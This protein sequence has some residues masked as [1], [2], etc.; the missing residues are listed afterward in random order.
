MGRRRP[1]RIRHPR[2]R[3]TC[4]DPAAALSSDSGSAIAPPPSGRPCANRVARATPGTGKSATTRRASST[5]S[6]R[7]TG[8]ACRT[9][10]TIIPYCLA[11]SGQS[12]V[13]GASTEKRS[14]TAFS[15]TPRPEKPWIGRPPPCHGF[16]NTSPLVT[17]YFHRRSA[18][19]CDGRETGTRERTGGVPTGSRSRVTRARKY[20][21][22]HDARRTVTDHVR[23][24]GQELS[25]APRPRPGS[26]SAFPP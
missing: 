18:T 19:R 8:V 6:G 21:P 26:D 23:S 2:V 20:A 11:R 7:T 16:H 12:S 25:A 24:S 9:T 14:R 17:T 5:S 15:R 1:R 3:S 10:I 4:R 22:D 13:C